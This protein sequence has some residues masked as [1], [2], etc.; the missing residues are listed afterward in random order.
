MGGCRLWVSMERVLQAC[1]RGK[2]K[3]GS[4][5]GT[6][7]GRLAAGKRWECYEVGWGLPAVIVGGGSSLVSSPVLG[8]REDH[9][10]LVPTSRKCRRIQ[11]SWEGKSW[12]A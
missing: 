7:W 5:W 11:K 3:V 10:K 6:Y 12:V 2:G 4:S 9:R 8:A 1:R